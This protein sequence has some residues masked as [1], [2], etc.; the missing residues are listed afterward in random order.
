MRRTLI[1]AVLL[2]IGC[3]SNPKPIDDP[4]SFT[5]KLTRG[6]APF[7]DVV[8][9]LQPM[10]SAYVANVNVK[11]DGT[12]EGTAVPGTYAYSI[13]PAQGRT[14]SDQSKF[15][16]LFSKVPE[17]FR[18]PTKERTVSVTSGASLSVAID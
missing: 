13:A 11:S 4:V 9:V 6:G 14:Q 3:N 5:G 10:H 17:S 18:T 12:F 2:M 8:L 1:A 7:G 15:D 16:A